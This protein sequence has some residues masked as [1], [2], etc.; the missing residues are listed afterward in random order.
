MFFSRSIFSF[1]FGSILASF[2]FTLFFLFFM[3]RF[4]LLLFISLLLL[5]LLPLLFKPI[6][7]S[8]NSFGLNTFIILSFLFLSLSLFLFLFKSSFCFFLFSSKS[9]NSFN[10][11]FVIIFTFTS[12]DFVLFGAVSI[13]L[14]DLIFLI[15][16]FFLNNFETS[17]LNGVIP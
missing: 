1:S 10:F 11:L 4:K 2:N 12:L 8:I 17:I 14:V 16:L 15:S 9:I 7:E 3:L 13:G 5:V 6:F